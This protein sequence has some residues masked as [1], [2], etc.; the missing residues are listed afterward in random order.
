MNPLAIGGL[1]VGIITTVVAVAAAKKKASPSGGVAGDPPTTPAID[2]TLAQMMNELD[3]DNFDKPTHR[4]PSAA[5]IA[6]ATA[7][8]NQLDQGGW[9]MHA[10]GL[11]EAI[12]MTTGQ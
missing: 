6:G 10:A 12:R 8:A 9:H 5:T 11:R 7:Y 4:V 3:V 1:V 2:Q